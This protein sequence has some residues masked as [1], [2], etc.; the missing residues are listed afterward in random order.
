MT[1]SERELAHLIYSEDVQ[2]VIPSGRR[3]INKQLSR[4]EI[5]TSQ[6]VRIL[7]AV[8]EVVAERGFPATTIADIATR[9]GVSRGSFYEH[10]KGKEDC[11][12]RS[13][14]AHASAIFDAMGQAA[15]LG[16]SW[17]ESLRLGTEAYLA[18]SAAHPA[19]LHVYAFG[20]IS[21]SESVMRQRYHSDA[22]FI[23]QYRALHAQMRAADSRVPDLTDEVVWAC[24]SFSSE[25]V[26]Y[27][28]RTDGPD[29]LL[30][31]A[32]TICGVICLMLGSPVPA[33]QVTEDVVDQMRAL[34]FDRAMT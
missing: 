20:V 31:L 1:L 18:W 3:S 4:E 23:K 25:L 16:S 15:R 14:Q 13:Y 32:P 9:A 26:R 10:F 7:E 5:E 33:E 34:W 17:G 29:K 24:I 12:L 22:L 30:D 19:W 2:R 6:L 28:V 11:L 21:A 27:A 8:M